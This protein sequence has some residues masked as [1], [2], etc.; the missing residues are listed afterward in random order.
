MPYS[1][2]AAT[3]TKHAYPMIFVMG[4]G[5]VAVPSWPAGPARVATPSAKIATRPAPAA[6]P[7]TRTR[8]RSPHGTFMTVPLRSGRHRLLGRHARALRVVD[9]AGVHRLAARRQVDRAGQD[10][11]DGRD[12]QHADGAGL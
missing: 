10:D 7:T 2:A 5:T 6:S 1:T 11:A 8:P 9:V 3:I 12:D 4:D